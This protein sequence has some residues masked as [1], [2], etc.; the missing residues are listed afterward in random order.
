MCFAS[1]VSAAAPPDRRS[2]FGWDMARPMSKPEGSLWRR[3]PSARQRR[4]GRGSGTEGDRAKAPVRSPEGLT[5]ADE[6]GLCLPL[7]SPTHA[8]LV[9]PRPHRSAARRQSP[10]NVRGPYGAAGPQRCA[11]GGARAPAPRAPV[12]TTCLNGGVSAVCKV[13]L[14]TC[15]PQWTSGCPSRRH[16]ARD[17]PPKRCTRHPTRMP[18]H[19]IHVPV[20]IAGAQK[21]IVRVPERAGG[22]WRTPCLGILFAEPPSS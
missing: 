19:D 6:G 13:P 20:I 14:A 8:A 4:R 2:R 11:S 16:E 17:Y 1:G 18:P 22:R 15:R 9:G 7:W 10:P 21:R 12:A 5:P 3:L